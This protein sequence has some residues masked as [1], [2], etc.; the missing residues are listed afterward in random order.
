MP[1]TF[2]SALKTSKESENYPADEGLQQR[3]Q[4]TRMR[5]GQLPPGLKPPDF[6]DPGTS[7]I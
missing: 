1:S 5:L 7:A 4:V 3:L 2:R 6:C